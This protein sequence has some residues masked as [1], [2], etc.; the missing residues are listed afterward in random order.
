VLVDPLN[1]DS[2]VDGI[3]KAMSS[4]DELRARGLERARDASWSTTAELTI[5]A[6]RDTLERA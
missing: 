2:I 1:V 3:R 5:A 4:A 6:Y